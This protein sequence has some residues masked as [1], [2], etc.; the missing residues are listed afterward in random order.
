LEAG[1]DGL[2]EGGVD[3][4]GLYASTCADTGWTWDEVG[5]LTLPRLRA[6]YR[7]FRQQPPA[8]WLLAAW[9]G[10]K[11]PPDEQ[12]ERAAISIDDLLDMIPG[13]EGKPKALT[14]EMMA[15]LM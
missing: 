4:D 13:E 11:P 1:R 5:R 7:H 6:I 2:S 8:H 14:L 12:R 9:V 15:M 10:Y 3:W